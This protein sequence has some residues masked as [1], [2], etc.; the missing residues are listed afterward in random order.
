LVFALAPDPP[1]AK[2][3]PAVPRFSA[4]DNAG[5]F[6]EKITTGDVFITG[7]ENGA[8]TES[9]YVRFENIAGLPGDKT[10]GANAF[11]FY[12]DADPK[13]ERDVGL[14]PPVSEIKLSEDGTGRVVYI[15][16]PNQ[17]G[18]LSTDETGGRFE[19]IFVSDCSSG[20]TCAAPNPLFS[21]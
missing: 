14:P 19:Y 1:L 20:E 7:L 21:W 15:P 4:F 6:T 3:F 10:G 16:N 8:E 18:G 5:S 2:D 11:F 9:D 12:S 17:P 13:S